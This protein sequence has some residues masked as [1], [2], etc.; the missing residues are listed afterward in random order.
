MS[1]SRHSD[2]RPAVAPADPDAPTLQASSTVT[3]FDGTVLVA[4]SLHTEHPATGHADDPM[5]APLV[6]VD[7]DGDIDADTTP[8]LHTTL[9][10]TIRRHRQVCCDLSRVTFFGAAGVDTLFAVLPDADQAGCAFTVR[11][12]R[13]ISA[14]VFQITA[15]DTVLAS[16]V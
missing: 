8:L 12:V 16:R 7:V 5:E 9:T 4:I 13:G 3:G 1:H 15:L 14:R 2:S 10:H 11:G 6:V